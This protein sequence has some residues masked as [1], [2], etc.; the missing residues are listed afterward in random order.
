M[1]E[2]KY[3]LDLTD[4][5]QGVTHVSE[6]YYNPE[7]APVPKAKKNWNWFNFT[8][9]WAGMVHN[10]VQFEIAGLLTFEFGPVVALSLIHI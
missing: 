3:L 10:V 5:G 7:L 4:Y 1:E 6:N 9:V 8:T 2:G